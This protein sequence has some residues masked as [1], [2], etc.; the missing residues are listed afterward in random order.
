LR[1]FAAWER[2]EQT[3]D[4]PI[5]APFYGWQRSIQDPRSRAPPPAIPRAQQD[6]D[7]LPFRPAGEVNPEAPPERQGGAAMV[8]RAR[9]TALIRAGRVW[10]EPWGHRRRAGRG[11]D[12]LAGSPIQ[13]GLERAPGPALSA[14]RR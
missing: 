2:A 10:R 7:R 5:I 12:A 3:A 8:A 9:L 1:L 6:D 4:A 14:W 13:H 11:A